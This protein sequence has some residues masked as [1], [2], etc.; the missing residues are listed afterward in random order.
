MRRPNTA[1]AALLLLALCSITIRDTEAKEVGCR[2]KWG[3]HIEG[4][5]VD[6]AGNLYAVQ[7]ER[8]GSAIGRVSGRDGTCEGGAA[9]VANDRGN[10][11]LNGL[12]VLPDGSI[13]GAALQQKRVRVCFLFQRKA[14]CMHALG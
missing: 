9:A 4:A 3:P 10:I 12:R 13:L 11:Y 1:A 14:G 8:K 7:W 6:A 5:A 2:Q